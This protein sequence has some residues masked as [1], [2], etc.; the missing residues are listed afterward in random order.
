MGIILIV[1]AIFFLT[2]T[3]HLL[4]ERKSR[5]KIIASAIIT[6]LFFIGS[7]IYFIPFNFN[8]SEDR[9]YSVYIEVLGSPGIELDEPEKSDILEIG[10]KISIRRSACYFYN[11]GSSFFHQKAILI[12]INSKTVKPFHAHIYLLTDRPRESFIECDGKKYFITNTEEIV[13]MIKA[14]NL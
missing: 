8:I 13:D 10:R 5:R 14:L 4:K 11:G 3:I 9:D 12:S 6:L 7:I 1:S 2:A